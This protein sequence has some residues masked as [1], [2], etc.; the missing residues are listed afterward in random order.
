VRYAAAKADER[1]GILKFN[2]EL[3]KIRL[4][5]ITML[6]TMVSIAQTFSGF[7]AFKKLIEFEGQRF[8]M[9]EVY[10]VTSTD[11]D[12]LRIERTINE[13]DDNEGFMIVFASYVFNGKSGVVISAFSSRNLVNSSYSFTNIHLTTEEYIALYDLVS[14]MKKWPKKSNEQVLRRF[15]N[16]ITLSLEETINGDAQ[17]VLWIDNT[18]RHSFL[19]SK[20]D[21][22][23]RR[24]MKFIEE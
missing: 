10:E 14:V 22:A 17:I 6:C 18:S 19:D 2:R 5:T 4:F 24:H 12:L 23:Y 3:M 7:N 8:L 21:R 16:R 11:F 1:G 9:D 13:F 15:N 20:W